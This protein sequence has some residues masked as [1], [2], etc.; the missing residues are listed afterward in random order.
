M[1]QSKLLLKKMYK[2]APKCYDLKLTNCKH[3]FQN[4]E[5]VTKG[6]SDF[7]KMIITVLKTELRRV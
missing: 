7:H 2:G 5:A 1:K 6:F 3:N 4:T